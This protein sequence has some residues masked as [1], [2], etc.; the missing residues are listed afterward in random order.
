M[1]AGALPPY[2]IAV[3]LIMVPDLLRAETTREKHPL[4][5]IAKEESSR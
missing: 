2:P 3:S 4:A 1:D 5:N